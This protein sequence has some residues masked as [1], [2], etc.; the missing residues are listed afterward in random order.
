MPRCQSRGRQSCQFSLR[1]QQENQFAAQPKV[2]LPMQERGYWLSV[3][4]RLGFRAK[5]IASLRV[6]DVLDDYGRLREEFGLTGAMT[7]GGKPRAAYLTNLV[8]RQAI[9]EYLDERRQREDILFNVEAPLFRSQKGNA[10][11]PNT[12]QQLLRRLLSGQQVL[13]P[14]DP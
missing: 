11:T 2:D 4:Y 9:K 6:K 1:E 8:V 7:K 10:F 5:E 14:L 3:S 13:K 12:M